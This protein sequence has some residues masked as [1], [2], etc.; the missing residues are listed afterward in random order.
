[1]EAGHTLIF[2]EEPEVNLVGMVPSA[3]RNDVQTLLNQLKQTA[4]SD[5]KPQRSTAQIR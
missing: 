3:L 2:V 5:N 1:M 4:N